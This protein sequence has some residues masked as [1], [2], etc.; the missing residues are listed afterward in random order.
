MHSIVFGC[1]WLM[2]C[3][4]GPSRIHCRDSLAKV[5][6]FECTSNSVMN[7]ELIAPL[8]TFCWIMWMLSARTTNIDKPLTF[9]GVCMSSTD[10]MDHDFIWFQGCLC[11]LVWSRSSSPKSVP[12]GLP[13][14]AASCLAHCQSGSTFQGGE[15]GLNSAGHWWK[16]W[17]DDKCW[18]FGWI[19]SHFQAISQ[20]PE[21]KDVYGSWFW[22]KRH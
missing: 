9:H 17:I 20:Q 19:S 22:I 3:D 13:V 1:L 8:Q 15:S 5:L 6:D 21:L 14:S 16:S 2:V 12:W 11:H 10:T 7:L 18:R 4:L